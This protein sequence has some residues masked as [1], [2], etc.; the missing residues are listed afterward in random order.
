M[1]AGDIGHGSQIWSFFKANNKANHRQIT[2]RINRHPLAFRQRFQDNVMAACMK[3]IKVIFFCL[4]SSPTLKP[5]HQN[6]QATFSRCVLL[7]KSNRS[8]PSAPCFS[9]NFHFRICY[10]STGGPLNQKSSPSRNC[11]IVF[12]F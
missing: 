10:Y 3:C 11:R 5:I 1:T 6:L 8:S 9:F 2:R 4:F 12:A 7:R